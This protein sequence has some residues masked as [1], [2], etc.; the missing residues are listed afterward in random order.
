M[1]PTECL[2]RIRVQSARIREV[3]EQGINRPDQLADAAQEL[4]QAFDDL[5]EWLT[6]GG[7]VPNQWR[8]RLPVAPRTG[9]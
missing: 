9:A 3:Q 5:D 7:F 1:D 8:P 2:T 6:K 4:Q